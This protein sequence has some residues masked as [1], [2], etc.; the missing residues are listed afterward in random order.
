MC[1]GAQKTYYMQQQRKLEDHD[2]VIDGATSIFESESHEN[3][4]MLT[5]RQLVERHIIFRTCLDNTFYYF[6]MDTVIRFLIVKSKHIAIRRI[7]FEDKGRKLANCR[8]E[9]RTNTE[10]YRL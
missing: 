9:I 10:Y 1:V 6:E 8:T 3:K 4:S 2:F 7:L 5:E